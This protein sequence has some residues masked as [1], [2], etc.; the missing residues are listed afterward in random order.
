[1]RGMIKRL[2]I[3]LW[4]AA[5]LTIAFGAWLEAAAEEATETPKSEVSSV[6]PNAVPAVE[7]VN[8]K[9]SPSSK[10]EEKQILPD[11]S[12]SAL[13]TKPA[14]AKAIITDPDPEHEKLTALRKARDEQRAKEQIRLLVARLGGPS[15]KEAQEQ[16]RGFGKAA[17]PFL[18]EALSASEDGYALHAPSDFPRQRPLNEPVFAALN[19]LVRNHSDFKGV[20]PAMDQDGWRKWWEENKASIQFAAP[21]R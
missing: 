2:Q 17:V 20:V 1:M 12:K 15:N 4:S 11:A 14:P 6:P 5:I 21:A 13:K 7:P 16:L 18:I 19:N 8:L 10:A 3:G 9:Y